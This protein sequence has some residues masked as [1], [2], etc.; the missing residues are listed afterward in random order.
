MSMGSERRRENRARFS[1]PAKSAD[2]GR[3]HQSFR[4]QT[5]IRAIL[6]RAKAQGGY[7]PPPTREPVYGDFAILR[8]FKEAVDLLSETEAMFYALPAEVR[9]L[10]ANDV[11]T[12]MARLENVEFQNEVEAALGRAFRPAPP[13][14]EPTPEPAPAPEPVE[15]AVEP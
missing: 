15:P 5:N 8:D 14:P 6:K 12:F 2:D 4:G 11:Q 9:S 1:V 3:T 7:L 13:D 10:G